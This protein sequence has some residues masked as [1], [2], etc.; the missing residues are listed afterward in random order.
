MNNVSLK[1][2]PLVHL[3]QE[4]HLLHLQDRA[5]GTLGEIIVSWSETVLILYNSLIFLTHLCARITV[6]TTHTI[7]DSLVLSLLGGLVSYW[8]LEVHLYH[9]KQTPQLN[10]LQWSFINLV[11]RASSPMPLGP[12]DLDVSIENP[13]LTLQLFTEIIAVWTYGTRVRIMIA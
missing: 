12:E 8:V 13:T 3:D 7:Y 6:F 9:I 10:K 4:T 1:S 2:R 11:E 5:P